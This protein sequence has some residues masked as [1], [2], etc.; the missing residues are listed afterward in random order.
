MKVKDAMKTDVG[1]CSTEDNIMKTA[2]I[3]RLRDCGA[4]PVLDDENKFVGILTDRDICLA[5]AARNRKASDVQAKDLLKNKAITCFAEDQLDRALRK[6]RKYQVERLAV[7]GKDNEFTGMLTMTDVLLAVHK[8][9]DL[10][11]EIYS[12]LKAIAKP[13]PIVLYEIADKNVPT[14]EDLLAA[15]IQL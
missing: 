9:K 2:E 15:P 8:D 6:M 12:T 14:V 3:M 11:K 1:V 7:V 10:K 13:R 5:I 4:V